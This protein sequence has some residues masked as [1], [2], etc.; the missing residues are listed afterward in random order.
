MKSTAK[1]E[2]LA[3]DLKDRL[4]YRGLSVAESKTAQ[5]WPRL[6]IG[7]SAAS[8]EIEAVDAVSKDVFGNSLVAFAP[9]IARLASVDAQS[10]ADLS[11][12][13]LELAKTG[14]DKTI[15][16]VGADLTTA[17]ATAGEAIVFEVR[18]PTKGV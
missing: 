2:A 13:M 5:G 8:L 14:V 15:L 12:I 11:K 6:V 4:E 1:A 3:R 16:K 9:H 17:E 10:K 7:A 18:W